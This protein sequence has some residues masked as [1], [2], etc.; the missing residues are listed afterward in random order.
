MGSPCD[1][2]SRVNST[3]PMRA[4]KGSELVDPL[5]QQLVGRV[6]HVDARVRELLEVG[7]QVLVG[8]GAGHL[9]AL[10]AAAGVGIGIVFTV[11]GA[12]SVSTYL[13]SG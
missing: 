11:C 1:D 3:P 8:R 5:A 12:T 13:V 2:P 6:A 9:E 10:G 4:S 7:A